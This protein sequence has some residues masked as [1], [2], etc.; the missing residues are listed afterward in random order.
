MMPQLNMMRAIQSLAPKRSSSEVRG[1]F[2]QEVG[3]EEKPRTEAI[4]RLGEA[5]RR[6]S[7]AAWRSRRS[8]GRDRRRSSRRR[9]T[10][11]AATSPWKLFCSRCHPWRRFPPL[12]R[13]AP[14]RSV[15]AGMQGS[16][17]VRPGGAIATDRCRA[18]RRQ[19]ADMRAAARGSPRRRFSRLLRL[20]PAQH[21]KRGDG[22]HAD[23]HRDVVVG[24][25]DRDADRPGR[26]RGSAAVAVPWTLAAVLA[27]WRRRR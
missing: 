11:S 13:D 17:P 12:D 26:P 25:A 19:A 22:E 10:A 15:D 24:Q 3:D 7:S 20:E 9:G 1:H 2:Q 27:G 8:R 23:H 21:V 14:K 16:G 5:E 18:C 6:C 4:G